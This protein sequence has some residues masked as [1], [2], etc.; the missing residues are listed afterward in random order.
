[1]IKNKITLLDLGGVVFQSSGE[2]NE[3]INWEI[4]AKLNHIYGH[5]LNIGMDI[6][7]D[8]MSEYNI[9]TNQNLAGAEFLRLVFDT[10]AINTTLIDFIIKHS[11]II[12][13]SDNYRENIE[14]ISRRYD[15]NKWAIDQIYSFDYEM[16]KSD[17]RF[18]EKLVVDL[19]DHCVESMIFIDDSQTK[20]DSAAKSGIQGVLF[21]NN[22]QTI[23][24][25]SRYY[26]SDNT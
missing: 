5:D 25:L 21:K 3:K 18:F 6:F 26:A 17:L 14:Y 9:L 4:I 15:F 13:V 12:I 1:M 20:L 16:V 23:E 2:S 8:F 24:H 7:P 10:L 19:K 11:Q 22:T